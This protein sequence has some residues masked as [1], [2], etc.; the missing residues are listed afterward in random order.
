ME[1]TKATWNEE[2]KVENRAYVK[3]PDLRVLAI[4]KGAPYRC[5]CGNTKFELTIAEDAV[6]S[7]CSCG[8]GF[9]VI[10]NKVEE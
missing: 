10:S 5:S 3:T 8:K 9:M 2:T 7:H 4:A 6:M 1:K